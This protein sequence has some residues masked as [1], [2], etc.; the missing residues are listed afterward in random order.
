MNVMIA[1]KLTSISHTT[2]AI[3]MEAI[4]TTTALLVSSERDGHDTF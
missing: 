3:M 4:S 1:S 2:N